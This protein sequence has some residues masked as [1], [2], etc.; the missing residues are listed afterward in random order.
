MA[1]TAKTSTDFTQ[2]VLGRYVCNTLDEALTSTQGARDARPFDIIVIGGGSFGPVFAQHFFARDK[3]RH[4][5]ILVL[6]AGSLV[7]TQHFQNYP[8]MDYGPAGPV[9]ADPFVPRNEV[10]GLPWRF[11]KDNIP[12]G[13][14]GLAYCLGG[15][16]V[17][18]GGW[19]PRLLNE[20]MPDTLW[21]AWVKDE[22]Q[23][24]Y[25]DE[26]SEQIGTDASNDFINGPMHDALRTQLRDGV[27][28]GDVTDAL[29][30]TTDAELEAP[31]AVVA[32][33]DSGLFPFNKFSA[34]PLLI[35][36]ARKA[37]QDSGYSDVKK[38]LMVVPQCRVI[39]LITDVQNGVGRVTGVEVEVHKRVNNN[40]EPIKERKTISVPPNGQVVIALGTI[41]STRLALLSFAGI[42]NYAQIGQNLMAHL[43]SNLTIRIPREALATLD[44]NL[45]A[46]QGSALFMKGRHDFTDAS[47]NPDGTHGYFHLQITASGLEQTDQRADS[48]AE[49]FKMVPDVDQFDAMQQADDKHIVITIR[50]IGETQGRNPG[51]VVTLSNETDE[52]QVQRAFVQY[53]LSDKDMQL[54]RAMD[55]ASDDVAKVFAGGLSFEVRKGNQWL[56]ADATTDLTALLPYQLVNQPGGGRRDGMGTTHHE[57]GTLAIGHDPATSVCDVNAR[58]H[59]VENAFAAGPA[60]FPTVGS[61]NPMLT[62]VALA[63]RLADQLLQADAPDPDFSMLFDGTSTHNWRMST[64]VN[65]A[66]NDPGNFVL[67]DHALHSVPGNDLGLLWCTDPTPP[68][69]A[70][71]LEWKQQDLND[72]SG[73][74]VR[75]PDPNGKSY[76]NTAYVGVHFGFEVQIDQLAR[77]D[78]A[79]IHLTGAVYSLQGPDA[80]NNLPLKPIGEW[81]E[82]EIQVVGQKYTV[83]LNGLKIT[84]F[85]NTDPNRGLPSA[86]N[87]PSYVGMQTHTGRVSFR[88]IQIKAL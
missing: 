16:S 67:V 62:G 12:I 49:L 69:F 17:F 32:H 68:D 21:P 34:V 1:T 26:A 85:D 3:D 64:I 46:L 40:F 43:R 53:N 60:L 11:D 83:F 54:W 66:N 2:D 38:N 37:A 87:T 27:N 45:K 59:S 82:Y 35:K 10:W 7:L 19:S 76:N 29:N 30:P 52:V 28:G 15:R 79:A 41:E 55:I 9:E 6:D 81:N 4:H 57:A 18:F 80:P 77:D 47:G 13:F 25:F 75:F 31:L 39:R 5:R 58:F 42:S 70:L 84:E 78:G 65:Q 73:V 72:N 20:E 88:K 56:Q 8:P 61:P 44:P 50:G 86:P 51:S 36:A 74:F 71:K 48:E 63:R 33:T 24:R 22:L 14:T 23:T